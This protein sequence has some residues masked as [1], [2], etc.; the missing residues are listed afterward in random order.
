MA[1]PADQIVIDALAGLGLIQAPSDDKKKDTDPRVVIGSR[2]KNYPGGR[3]VPEQEVMSLS[4]MQQKVMSAGGQRLPSYYEL[5]EKLIKSGLMSRSSFYPEGVSGGV[6]NAV[7]VW[8]A[9]NA[10]GGTMN[11]TQWLD[12]YSKTAPDEEG[13]G[14]GGGGGG[15]TGPSTTTSMTLTDETTAEA[16]LDR[17][18]RDLLGRGLTKKETNKYIKQFRESEMESPQVTTTMPGGPGRATQVTETAA[19]KDELLRQMIS[20]N[21]DYQKFQVDTTIM[22]MLMDDIEK[23]K[24]VIYG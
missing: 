4:T 1:G 17:F 18:A 23:G 22:D 11:F 21:P 20:S 16:L 24:K 12:W 10:D 3:S 15:Y 7:R 19:S 5:G 13:S 9:Y 8:Q 14:R 6:G 2:P